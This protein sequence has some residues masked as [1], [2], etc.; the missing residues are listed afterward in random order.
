M[1]KNGNKIKAI[2]DLLAEELSRGMLYWQIASSLHARYAKSDLIQ[3]PTLLCGIY[4]ACYNQVLLSLAKLGIYERESV[5]LEYLLNCASQNLKA[6]RYANRNEL[7]MTIQR[8]RRLLAERKPFFDKVKAAR[9]RVL[10][11]LD[12]KHINDPEIFEHIQIQYEEIERA[13]KFLLETLNCYKGFYDRSSIDLSSSRLA[14]NNDIS[15]MVG[16]E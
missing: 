16:S 14:L 7:E 9:D 6:F 12:S 10:A 15:K 3:S 13:F 2:L 1:A 4:Q 5:S 8:H 11:H